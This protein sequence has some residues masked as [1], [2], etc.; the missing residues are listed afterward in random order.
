MTI[1]FEPTPTPPGRGS[2]GVNLCGGDFINHHHFVTKK[3]NKKIPGLRAEPFTLS[4]RLSRVIFTGDDTLL[5]QGLTEY[6][7]TS[8]GF[9]DL[10]FCFLPYKT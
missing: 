6:Q 8:S 1:K 5:F 3:N 2:S 10:H 4:P 9:Q 7:Y